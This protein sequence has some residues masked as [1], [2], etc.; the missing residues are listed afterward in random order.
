MAKAKK[1]K[2][3]KVIARVCGYCQSATISLADKAKVS[4]NRG[5]CWCKK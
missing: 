2:K 4:Q 1:T 3:V 5:G